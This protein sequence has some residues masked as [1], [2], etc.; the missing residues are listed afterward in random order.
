MNE[1]TQQ[2]GYFIEYGYNS[3]SLFNADVE[4]LTGIVWVYDYPEDYYEDSH[5]EG[6]F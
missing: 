3:I 6:S 4:W 1:L 2:L 5:Y